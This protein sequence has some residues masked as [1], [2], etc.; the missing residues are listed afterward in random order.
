MIIDLLANMGLYGELSA[1]LTAGLAYLTQHDLRS[2]APGRVEIEGDRL[3]AI[4]QEYETK[5]PGAGKWEAHRRYW[6]IQYVV[7]GVECLHYANIRHL[8]AG[9]YNAEKDFLP[10]QGD[11][12][13]VTLREGM[14]AILSPQDAHMPGMA[15]EQPLRVRK[16]VVKVAV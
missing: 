15:V 6:D 14:V 10:L 3:F 4:I 8:P 11:G 13:R 12:D 16:V 5:L 2:L 9:D 1:G 7:R